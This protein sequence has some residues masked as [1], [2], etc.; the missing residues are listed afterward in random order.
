M[1]LRVDWRLYRLLYIFS[2]TI[3]PA[4]RGKNPDRGPNGLGGRIDHYTS[5]IFSDILSPEDVLRVYVGANFYR[6]IYTH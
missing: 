2:D 5:S 1:I 6:Y 3:Q 4:T